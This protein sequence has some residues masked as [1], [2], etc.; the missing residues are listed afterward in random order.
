MSVKPT[1]QI[2]TAITAFLLLFVSCDREDRITDSNPFL[3]WE[4]YVGGAGSDVGNAIISTFDDGCVVV[5]YTYSFGA[6]GSDIYLI[7]MNRDGD[8]VWTKTYGADRYDAGYSIAHTLNGGYIIAGQTASS[9]ASR[10]DIF[11]IKVDSKGNMIWKR[12]YGGSRNEAAYSIETL[13]DGNSIIAGFTDSFGS[14]LGVYL[15]KINQLGDTL[16]S[17]VLLDDVD[18]H[19]IV[20]ASNVDGGLYITG[21]HAFRINY[22]LQSDAFIIKTNSEGDTLFTRL[23]GGNEDEMGYSVVATPDGGCIAAGT[24]QSFGA[25]SDD[26]Y[27]IRLNSSGDIVWT[28]AYGD[29]GRD[30]ANYI[31][32]SFDGNYIIAGSTYSYAGADKDILLMK[33]DID[34][35]LIW[36][37]SIGSP[38]TTEWANSVAQAIDGGYVLT[39]F[40]DYKSNR[41]VYVIKTDP[42]GNL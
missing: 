13:P 32:S 17:K 34:G 1:N 6:G 15:L 26:V 7:R 40:R 2:L 10:Y 3:T 30:I 22:R 38:Y 27:L 16:W 9:A 39:G 4:T 21:S 11:L 37:K 5:G 20:A 25:G 31:I 42:D 12:L 28:R 24:T 29:R 41:Y 33:I 18:I 36:A 8:T 19:H 35:N 14:G 23:I